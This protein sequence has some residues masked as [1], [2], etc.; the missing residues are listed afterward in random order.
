MIAREVLLASKAPKMLPRRKPRNGD[1]G[2][3]GGR[4]RRLR[5]RL[6]ACS[7]DCGKLGHYGGFGRLGRRRVS[8]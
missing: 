3:D 7:S 4:W 6:L 8:P 5:W 2:G 1:M